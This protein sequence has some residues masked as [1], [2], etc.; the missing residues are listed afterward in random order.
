MKLKLILGTSIFL[1]VSGQV[2]AAL[3]GMDSSANVYSLDLATS[4]SSFVSGSPF[5]GSSGLAFDPPSPALVLA[6]IWLFGTALI[7]LA[8]FSKR[9]RAA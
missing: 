6:A 2:N 1:L 8:G 9:R 4:S 3:Y 7:G 5:W